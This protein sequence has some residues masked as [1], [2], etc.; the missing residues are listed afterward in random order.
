MYNI[1]KLLGIILISFKRVINIDNDFTPDDC[2][3]SEQ[4][5]KYALINQNNR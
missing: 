2:Y 3:V 4:L 1:S 5:S